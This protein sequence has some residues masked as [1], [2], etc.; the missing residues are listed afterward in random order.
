M[1]QIYFLDDIIINI[2]I[3]KIMNKKNARG[4]DY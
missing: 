3:S 4:S 2:I 1:C